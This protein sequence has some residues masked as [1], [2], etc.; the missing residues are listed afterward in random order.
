[1]RKRFTNWRARPASR[2]A[3]VVLALAAGVAGGLRPSAQQPPASQQPAPQQPTDVALVIRGDGGA[4]P[5]YAVPAFT[6]AA[7]DVA[8]VAKVIGPVLWDDL[9]FEREVDLIPRDTAATVPP[10]RAADQVPFANWRE[11]GADAVVFGLVQRSGGNVS[12]QVQANRPR[13]AAR[14]AEAEA[15]LSAAL[16]GASVSISATTSDGLG[17]T[18]R[19][20]GVAAF[21]VA[22]VTGL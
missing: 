20:E 13:L 9:Q 11:I 5:R 6:A 10:A 4:R 1:M 3:I 14:R 19:G 15:A 7:P 21:A 16:G 12:V 18:G 17:F 22:L 2:G 8:D